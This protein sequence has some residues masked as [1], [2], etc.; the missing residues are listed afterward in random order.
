M[1]R[2]DI[3]KSG[4]AAG[5]TLAAVPVLSSE[6]K[7]MQ[8][9]PFK[10]NYAPH[11]GMFENHAGKDP[12]DQLKFAADEGF[13][14]WED[15]GMSGNSPAEQER[16]GKAMASLGIQMG[17]FVV[18][19]NTAWTPFL[20][21]GKKDSVDA[22]VKEC[23]NAVEVCKRINAK[24]MTFVPGTAD[25]RLDRG[26]QVANAIDGI[27]R[28]A[29]VLE[30]H[31]LVMVMEALNRRRD[32][33]GMLL[34]SIA[35]NYLIVRGVNSPALKILFDLYH[36]AVDDGN[37]IPHMDLCWN[38]IGYIQTGDHPGRNEPGTGEVN[39]RNVM[40]H[41]HGKGYKGILGMEHGKS[42]G[43]K[44]GERAVIDAYRAADNF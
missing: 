24:W 34:S 23:Q 29:E 22:F 3:L 41:I 20:A 28:G 9:G 8:K 17:I 39:Y 27:R 12:V 15:N 36:Q 6:A 44:E 2:R 33:P 5:A 42:K 43:G 19:P 30:K 13:R 14:A 35:D 31:G 10:L 37:L 26:Y 1:T 21:T 32:H 16:L 4:L 40:K 7:D 11:F 38:E 18:N 25:S